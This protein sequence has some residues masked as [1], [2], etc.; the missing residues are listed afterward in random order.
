MTD[1]QKA[2]LPQ[3]LRKLYT[4]LKNKKK[5]WKG[6]WQLGQSN[7]RNDYLVTCQECMHKFMFMGR[8]YDISIRL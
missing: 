3:I 2:P 8:M 4:W 1:H 5:Q 7:Q 6:E